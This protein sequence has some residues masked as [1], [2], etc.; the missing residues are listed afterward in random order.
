MTSR[1]RLHC[2][3]VVRQAR[4]LRSQ[5][6]DT[7]PGSQSGESS[8]VYPPGRKILSFG[9][10]VI[11]ANTYMRFEEAAGPTVNVKLVELC[12]DTVAMASKA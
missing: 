9:Q 11:I 10:E 2:P 6:V 7:Q 12:P 8:L 5:R 4:H 3:G 1:E